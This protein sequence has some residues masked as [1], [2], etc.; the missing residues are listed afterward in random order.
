MSH[1]QTNFALSSPRQQRGAALAV[2]I[3]IIVVMSILGVV[4]IRI[5]GNLGQANVSDVYSARAYAAARSGAEVFLTDLFPLN[6]PVAAEQCQVRSA[7]IPTNLVFSTSYEVSGL[8]SCHVEVRCDRI[9]L[10]PPF[11][12]THFRITSQG[13]CNAGDMTY[14]RQLILEAADEVF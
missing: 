12:G 5:L 7:D 1:N 13:R 3:F 8:N 11:S 10:E 9:D 2:A 6:S 4:M 14:S